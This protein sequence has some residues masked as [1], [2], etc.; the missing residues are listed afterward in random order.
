MY[1]DPSGLAGDAS[2]YWAAGGDGFRLHLAQLNAVRNVAGINDGIDPNSTAYNVGVAT[3]IANDIAW[4]RREGCGRLVLK[5]WA[6][7]SHT[8]YQN[9]W[10]APVIVEREFSR[11]RSTRS[12]GRLSIQIHVESLE[13]GH[14]LPVPFLDN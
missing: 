2:A 3:G 9:E 8:G 6:R 1:V 5:A 10:V 11:A 13:G 12:I 4:A 7:N 14:P